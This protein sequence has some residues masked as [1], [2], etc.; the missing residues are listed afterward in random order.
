M[1]GGYAMYTEHL[2][3]WQSW[4]LF[5]LAAA[6]AEGTESS[7][8]EASTGSVVKGCLFIRGVL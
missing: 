7:L 2:A 5:N 3:T 8:Q 6:G 1:N 4:Q